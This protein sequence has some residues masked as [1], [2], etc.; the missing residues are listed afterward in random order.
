MNNI[1]LIINKLQLFIKENPFLREK[2]KRSAKPYGMSR[3]ELRHQYSKKRLKELSGKERVEELDKSKIEMMLEIF[4]RAVFYRVPIDYVL[5]D[6]WFTCQALIRVVRSKNV[7]LI[8]MYRIVKAKFLYR[9]KLM[10]Y[11]QINSSIKEITRCRKM[12]LH[13]KRADVLLDG[14][15]VTLFF[16]RQG[17]RGKW[18]VFLTTDTKLSFVKL[19][20]LYQI[21]WSIEVFFKETKQLLNLGGCQSNDFDAQIA[22]TTVSMIAYILLSFRYRYE[23]YESMGE[24]F[25][26]MNAEC[27][28]Q[29]LDER[30]WGL[31]LELLR[32]ICEALEKDIDEL[33]ELIMN[34]PNTAEL[35]SRMLAPPLQEAV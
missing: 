4:Y 19:M 26:V 29:T 9:G 30:L 23:H 17:K 21:R 27:L 11:K 18:K 1:Q 35:V 2:G 33:F 15:P 28:Q 24:L 14:M 22:D 8:G 25:R 3:K 16:S 34:C 32:E 31:F 6:S 7:H 13:Y 10:N 20:E 5:C 12:R